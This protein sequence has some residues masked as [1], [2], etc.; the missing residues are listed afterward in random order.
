MFVDWKKIINM[1]NHNF[2]LELLIMGLHEL[3][4]GTVFLLPS[5]KYIVIFSDPQHHMIISLVEK[6]FNLRITSNIPNI[7]ALLVPTLYAGN[8]IENR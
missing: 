2:K 7:L 5:K 4:L 8:K 1:K 3:N 6:I